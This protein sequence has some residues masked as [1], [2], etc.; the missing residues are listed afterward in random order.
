MVYSTSLAMNC[1]LCHAW[2]HIECVNI[3]EDAYHILE[4][5]RGSVWLC[6]C[7]EET[8]GEILVRVDKLAEENVELKN[9]MMK[10][11]GVGNL[12]GEGRQ[13]SCGEC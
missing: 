12:W 10:A 1:N 9:R 8:F 11:L 6:E 7:C 3:D 5:M 13:I 2:F 4:S